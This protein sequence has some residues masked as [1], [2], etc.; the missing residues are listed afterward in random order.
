[1]NSPPTGE[2][3]GHC[4]AAL[5]EQSTFCSSCG[6]PAKDQAAATNVYP[7]RE[8]AAPNM[9][10]Q[11]IGHFRLLGVLGTGGFATVYVADDNRLGRQVAVKLLHPK[12]ARDITFVRR[13]ESE[14]RAI[15]RL[16]HPRIVT[17][18]E[19]GEMPDGSPYRV[20]TLLKGTLLSQLIKKSGRLPLAEVTSVLTQLASALD[21]LHEEGLVH[22][23]LKPAN[24]MVDDRGAVTLMDFGIA[25]EVNDQAH[26]TLAGQIVGTPTYMAPEQMLGDDVGPAADIYALGILAYELLTGKPPFAGSSLSVIRKHTSEPP[27][28]LLDQRPGMPPSVYTAVMA[29]LEKEPADRPTSAG[30][31]AA[32]LTST[33]PA[34]PV[35]SGGP[36]ARAPVVW[37]KQQSRRLPR[38]SL[39]VGALVGVVLLGVALFD[40][41]VAAG[42][43]SKPHRAATNGEQ[44]QA[45]TIAVSTA[46][47]AGVSPAFNVSTLAGSGM[48]GFADGLGSAAQFSNP[49][50]VAVD[51]AGNLYVSDSNNQ[52]IRKIAP[53]GLVTTVAGPGVAGSADGR[54]TSSQFANPEGMAMDKA[55]NLYVADTGN[56][57]IRKITP[58]GDVTTIAGSGG[59]GVG[60]GGLADGPGASA[61]FRLPTGVAVDGGGNLY[62]ADT[63]N[64]RIRKISA[65]GAV[66]TFAGSGDAGPSGG[67]FADGPGD[68]A[69]FNAP[70][71]VA[72]DLTG[73]VYV[74]DTFSQRIRK[75]T[76]AGTVSTLAGSAEA[77]DTDG[78]GIAARFSNP[79][80][81]AVDSAGNVYVADASNQRIR[82]ITTSGIVTTIAGSGAEGHADGPARLAQFDFP[83]GLAVDTAGSLYVADSV[84]NLI[85]KLVP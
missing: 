4:G 63:N 66:S 3:C 85:R 9:T 44:A 31:F 12:L 59:Y 54:R 47:P 1:M 76:P 77:G 84:D 7:P 75:I 32:A 62:V 52:R 13:F 53:S 69:R 20:M 67:G 83:K 18:H 60:G 56:N 38:G 50:A 15:A 72:A 34:K 78:T 21:F 58:D 28:S 25:R 49:G 37:M 14:A 73:N 17:I 36:G 64:N 22:R 27:P 40:L 29:A 45:G 42:S 23:D 70:G 10:G 46:V 33:R 81:L 19:V 2:T 11:Q 80:G 68:S 48:A 61:Q 74:A 79:A 24:V 82:K 43:R 30:A 71:G 57:R 6:Q 41:F 55:G 8:G 5:T 51:G 26:L 35:A 39:I 65:D 16:H